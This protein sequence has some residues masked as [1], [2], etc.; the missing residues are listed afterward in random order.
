MA[1]QRSLHRNKAAII[2]ITCLSLSWPAAV[3]P[4]DTRP[5]AVPQDPLL[6]DILARSA[7]YC[8]KVKAMALFYVCRPK[9]KAV[10][11]SYRQRWV[12]AGPVQGTEKTFLQAKRVK[13]EARGSRT[14]HYLYDYQLVNKDG[15][16]SERWTL[17]G[18]NG[19]KRQQEVAGP[20]DIR[21]SAAQLVYGPVGFLANSW[22][23][24]FRY[25]VGGREVVDDREAV[26]IRCEPRI[27]GRDND[28]VGRIWVD[29]ED[30]SILQIEWEPSS[31][32][33]YNDKA[34]EGYGR[35]VVWK[36]S[37]GVEKNGVR[38]PSRQ[39]VQEYLLDEKGL[40]IP[41]EEVTFLYLD[42]KF[43]TVGVEV[44]YRS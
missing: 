11:F 10:R 26:V 39:V 38:F 33:G 34:P 22:Q 27:R 23:D 18:E 42:Y 44:K 15:A 19:R 4:Q 24:H 8:E 2:L 5:A 40:K 25:E 31:I 12:D 36:V 13:F 3:K 43:F 6:A 30:R 21:F 14:N 32:E 37:Y 29:S 28:N 20:K 17:I 7:A 16:V 9:I 41:L 1:S 35:G